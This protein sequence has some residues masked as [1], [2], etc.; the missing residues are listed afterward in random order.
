M[1]DN[2]VPLSSEETIDDETKNWPIDLLLRDKLDVI[3][4]SHASG[5]VRR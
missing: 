4:H 2:K 1:I 3:K 5:C